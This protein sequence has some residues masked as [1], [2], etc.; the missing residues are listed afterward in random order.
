MSPKHDRYGSGLVYSESCPC[1]VNSQ[2]YLVGVGGRGGGEEGR[3]VT[4]FVGLK[5]LHRLSSVRK[6]AKDA[7]VGEK[8]YLPEGI[9]QGDP[10]QTDRETQR[11][12]GRTVA[13]LG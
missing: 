5:K 7:L 3:G 4:A 11:E 8:A 13:Y 6:H 12:L 9:V 10:V 1:V 2:Q